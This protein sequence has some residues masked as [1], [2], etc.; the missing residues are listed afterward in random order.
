MCHPRY[1]SH[2]TKLEG[3]V[4]EAMDRGEVRPCDPARLALVVAESSIALMLRRLTEDSP[5]DA[6]KDV[7]W[8]A[9]VLWN[10]LATPAPKG[11]SR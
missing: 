8:L 11:S 2:L 10:G 6:S 3:M 4:R 5:P 9:D 1:A 7:A